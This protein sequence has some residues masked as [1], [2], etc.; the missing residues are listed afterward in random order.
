M[1]RVEIFLIVRVCDSGWL[2]VRTTQ[3]HHKSEKFGGTFDLVIVGIG[4]RLH[5]SERQLAAK[6]RYGCNQAYA[7]ILIS[8]GVQRTP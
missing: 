8:V 5:K 3:H 2:R 6:L 1:N 4:A 7:R